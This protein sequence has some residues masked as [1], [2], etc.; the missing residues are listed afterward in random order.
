MFQLSIYPDEQWHE[1]TQLYMT[2]STHFLPDRYKA[3]QV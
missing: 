3:I 1:L 2:K